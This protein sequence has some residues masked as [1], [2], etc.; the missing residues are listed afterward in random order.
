ME[1]GGSMPSKR[2]AVLTALLVAQILTAQ[3]FAQGDL[4]A[5]ATQPRYRLVDMGTFGGP[6]SLVTGENGD[7]NQQKTLV[8]SCADTSVLDPEWPN[9][10]PFFGD[11]LYVQHAFWTR[12]GTLHDLGVLP[13]GTSSCGQGIN[14]HGTVT[15]FS[16]NG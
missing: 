12:R 4:T 13:G 7:L 14:T 3:L 8:T 10:N 5:E 16:T 6:V 2:L 9:I 11:D 1:R 15:G